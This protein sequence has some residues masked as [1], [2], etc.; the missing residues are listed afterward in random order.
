MDDITIPRE[1]CCPGYQF[2]NT[3]CVKESDD[4]PGCQ[5]PAGYR[6]SYD[7]LSCNCEPIC[8]NICENGRCAAP[9][10]CICNN[11]YELDDEFGE[12][13]EVCSPRCIKGGCSSP[14]Q[15]ICYDGYKLKRGS[16]HECIP[17][18][19][20]ECGHG[21]E[22]KNGECKPICS[23]SCVNA[24]CTGPNQC[25][26]NSGFQ[27]RY[28]SPFECVPVRPI[29]CEHGFEYENGECKLICSPKCKNGICTRNNQ[30]VCYEGYRHTYDS[31][32]ECV[33]DNYGPICDSDCVFGKCVGRN[34][35]ECNIGY[36]V[37]PNDRSGCIPACKF[38]DYCANGTCTY[39]GTCACNPGFRFSNSD[40]STCVPIQT[41]SGNP[42][43]QE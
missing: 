43:R 13:R 40:R 36:F 10:V 27:S 16:L 25:T 7:S 33:P 22:F 18:S 6:S 3:R 20:T 19:Q 29:E 23:P 24:V 17:E 21:Y 35:C 9:N 28:E 37:D 32:H 4:D 34:V 42:S 8:D 11:G 15:C 14:N 30:C 1:K 39:P 38:S 41:Y 26:C 5:C 2:V 31:S 12:C